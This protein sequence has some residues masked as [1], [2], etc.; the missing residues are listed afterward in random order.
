MSARK[1]ISLNVQSNIQV[2]SGGRCVICYGTKTFTD[3]RY[4]NT[5]IA[6]IDKN[7]EN[8]NED[9]LALLCIPCHN[10][11]DST[12]RQGKNYTQETVKR[13]RNELYEDVKNRN[14]PPSIN[15][16][17]FQSNAFDAMPQRF[18][19]ETLSK[20]RGFLDKASPL[21]TK[22]CSE[23]TYLSI[24]I[25][26][27]VLEY[28]DDNFEYWMASEFRCRNQEITPLQDELVAVLM[29]LSRSYCYLGTLADAPKHIIP[30]GY[31]RDIGQ[32]IKVSEQDCCGPLFDIID[33]RD[34][35]ILT[36]L[37]KLSNLLYQLDALA[38]E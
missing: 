32:A 26:H 36:Q 18:S 30:V 33:V 5:Q 19:E 16:S 9:N 28:I 11:Y 24:R 22:L 21:I 34:E 20:L 14:L 3:P 12:L 6:H 35:W 38:M 8:N 29:E 25:E 1:T 37:R 13:W 27:Y 4:P 17:M 10:L 2:N 31:Y 23:G 15:P 7:N